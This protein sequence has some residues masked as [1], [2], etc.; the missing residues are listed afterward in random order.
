MSTEASGQCLNTLEF[1]DIDASTLDNSVTNISTCNFYG[2]YAIVTNVDAGSNFQINIPDDGGYITVREGTFDGAVV[3]QGFAPLNISGASGADLFIHFNGDASCSTSSGCILTTIQCLSCDGCLTLSQFSTDNLSAGDNSVVTQSTCNIVNEYNIV[4][5]IS[6]FETIEFTATDGAYIVVRSTSFDGPIVGEGFSPV[7]VNSGT[8]EALFSH[9]FSDASCGLSGLGCI[10]TTVQCTTCPFPDPMDGDC[11]NGDDFG[12]A[13]LSEGSNVSV[14]LA[15]CAFSSEYSEV[16]GV[17]A[18]EDILFTLTNGN[19]ITVREGTPNGPVVAQGFAPVTVIGAS[20]ANLYAHWSPDDACGIGGGCYNA[21]VQCTSCPDCPSL[22]LNIGDACDDG[23]PTTGNDVVLAGCTC[24]GQ[25][26]PPNNEPCNAIAINCGASVSGSTVTAN[27]S[28][29]GSP[30]CTFGSQEDVFYSIFAIPGYTYEVT[31]NGT[32]YD[33]VLAAYT[34]ACDGTLTVIECSDAGLAVNIAE[35]ITF[36]VTEAQSVLIRTYD[37]FGSGG[38]YTLSVNCV[39]PNTN[40]ADA[41]PIDFGGDPVYGNN[42]GAGPSGPEMDCAFEGDGLQNVVWYELT[43]PVNGK[44]IIETQFEPGVVTLTDTQIQLLDACGGEV[45][46]CSEDFALTLLSRIELDC[47]EFDQGANYFLQVDGWNGNTGTFKIQTSTESCAAPINDLCASPTNL[48]LNLP[49]GCPGNALEG[50]TLGSNN[51]GEVAGLTCEP[52]NPDVFYSFNSGSFSE[53]NLG[54][55]AIDSNTDLVV[56]IYE[57]CSGEPIDCTV[58]P[59]GPVSVSVSQ[60]TDYIV[61]I[62]T[63]LSFGVPGSFNICLQGVFD[64]PDLNANIGNA[65]NDGN[66]DTDNDVVLA[67]CTCQGEFD[68]PDL[69]LNIDDSCDDGNPNTIDDTVNPDCECVGELVEGALVTSFNAP[70]ADTYTVEL[71]QQGTANLVTTVSGPVSGGSFTATG[72]PAGTYDVFVKLN[73]HLK[74]GF[75]GITITS[76]STSLSAGSFIPGD[77][78]NDNTISIPDYGVFSSSYSTSLGDP[79]YNEAADVNCDGDI[80]IVDFGIFSFNYGTDGDEP[81]IF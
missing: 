26:V 41:I 66:P 3:T 42:T 69:G 43:A 59:S 64:C 56:G 38:S 6:P 63:N 25:P 52:G 75:A 35:T 31:V 68:C 16:T 79:G 55:N 20:G 51:E 8:G 23:D 48:P 33:G 32:D 76:G 73:N 81:P 54:V 39:L 74:K 14:T 40:C 49:G 1:G 70:C 13:D 28:D 11:Y 57:T 45:I 71:Y 30:G 18:G 4:T 22:G 12:G 62:S 37:W 29:L 27:E 65:C 7:Q 58:N 44:M 34:G 53:I 15:N 50:T 47:G 46:A 67:D 19:Y 72:L 21:T 60:G 5:D 2:D 61:R 78:N 24:Q 77:I 9:Y 80:N 17:P 10:E 36:S